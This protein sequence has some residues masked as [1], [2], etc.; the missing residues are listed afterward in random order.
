MCMMKCTYSVEELIEYLEGRMCDHEKEK[1]HGHLEVCENCRNHL[2]ILKLTED[3][4]KEDVKNDGTTYMKVMNSIDK[5]RYS[6]KKRKYK[7]AAALFKLAPAFK[8]MAAAVIIIIIALVALNNQ[9][10]I[11][12]VLSSLEQMVSK[13]DKADKEDVKKED[14]DEKDRKTNKFFK[15]QPVVE[16]KKGEPAEGWVLSQDLTVKGVGDREQITIKLYV[17]PDISASSSKTATGEVMAFLND[18]KDLYEIGIISQYGLIGTQVESQDVN[19]DRIGEIVIK[20]QMGSSSVMFRVIGLESASGKWVQLLDTDY[21]EIMDLDL[22]GRNELVTTSVGSLP[23]YVWIYRWNQDHFEKMDVAEATGNEYARIL[24]GGTGIIRIESGVKD[25]KHFYV[26]KDGELIEEQTAKNTL[27]T[28]NVINVAF[29]TCVTSEV[30]GKRGPGESYD[31]LVKIPYGRVISVI[32]R[33]NKDAG[34]FLARLTPELS[35]ERTEILLPENQTEFWLKYDSVLLEFDHSVNFDQCTVNDAVRFNCVITG[36]DGD[37]GTFRLKQLPDEDSP[38]VSMAAQ[39][40]LISVMSK[41]QEWSLIKIISGRAMI[42]YSDVGWIKNKDYAV[43]KPGMNVNQGFITRPFRMYG[44]PDINSDYPSLEDVLKSNIAPVTVIEKDQSANGWT[45]VSGGFNGFAGWVRNEDL[46][47]SLTSEEAQKLANPEV[48]LK[49]L[50]QKIKEEIEG[51]DDLNLCALDID[52]QIKLTS[53]QRRELARKLSEVKGYDVFEGGLTTFRE[54]VYPFYTLQF[55]DGNDDFYMDE[56]SA[57]PP[58][59]YYGA[60]FSKFN[61]IVTAD[62]TLMIQIP[63]EKLAS[64][65]LKRE[66]PPVKFIK[67]NREFIEYF[68]TLIPV[69]ADNDKSSFNYILNAIKVEVDKQAGDTL[70]QVYKCAR[71]IKAFAGE[72]VTPGKS[73]AGAPVMEFKFTFKDGSTEKVIV[74]N[75]YLSYKGR[76]YSLKSAPQK[77]EGILFAGYF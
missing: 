32:G 15:A 8:P 61:F 3:Q 55:L 27:E 26:Y 12:N 10:H 29:N 40:N 6:A 5:N 20:G 42:D 24:N 16:L 17:K 52:K 50:T 41:G 1:L 2:G 59:K 45:R 53:G 63:E 38:V 54:A 77:I 62:D 31:N 35:E 66:G 72:E 56:E 44:K 37:D 33:H 28:E 67:V 4:I 49:L 64:Y 75:K 9:H 39:G 51:W 74:Y 69:K 71:V 70:K 7:V 11:S 46:K 18:G 43:Y 23:S 65:G 22:D 76:Y 58:Y 25:R 47:F 48:D 19:N 21:T 60:S 57:E 34:W 30:W 68:K 36:R 13:H 14:R 73:G